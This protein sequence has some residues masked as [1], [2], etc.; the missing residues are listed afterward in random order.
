MSTPDPI[1]K[2]VA[3]AEPTQA[4][5]SQKLIVRTAGLLFALAA[6]FAGFRYF[7]AV[8]NDLGGLAT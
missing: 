2:P 5:I 7:E 1:K 3:S 4:K 8:K 6:L